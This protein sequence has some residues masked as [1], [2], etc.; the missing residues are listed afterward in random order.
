MIDCEDRVRRM[1][2][3]RVR[4]AGGRRGRV[5]GYEEIGPGRVIVRW[6]DSHDLRAQPQAPRRVSYAL[7]D[8]RLQH[9]VE[10]YTLDGGWVPL[11]RVIAPGLYEAPTPKSKKKSPSKDKK[12]N[13][14][15]Y[16][17]KIGPGPRGETNAETGKW[18]CKK[19]GK[20]RQTCTSDDGD[21]VDITVDK[22]WKRAYNREYY[23]KNKGK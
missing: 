8:G 15:N 20:Y 23:K 11:G 1:R 22:E 10:V 19:S 9:E 4:D 13:P 16:Q 3:A 21:L 18:S 17:N 6:G 14:F 7:G 5:E 12:H 2:D